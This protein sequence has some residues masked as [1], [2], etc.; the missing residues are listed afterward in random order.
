GSDER[1]GRIRNRRPQRR[2]VRHPQILQDEK[3]CRRSS[4]LQE[5]AL[6]VSLHATQRPCA[7]TGGAA[8][9]S[10]KLAPA[11]ES[12]IGKKGRAKYAYTRVGSLLG[13]R[14][15]GNGSS[16]TTTATTSTRPLGRPRRRPR[17]PPSHQP[18]AQRRRI[19]ADPQITQR[20][21]TP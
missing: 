17:C 15:T 10:P 8:I 14:G 1:L 18:T 20:R 3:H 7:G 12:V 19:F 6:L 5:G 13:D 4:D 2:R 11:P 16:R 9:G 21:T